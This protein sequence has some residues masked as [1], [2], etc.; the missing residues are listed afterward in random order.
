MTE[1]VKGH[2]WNHSPYRGVKSNKNCCACGW[3]CEQYLTEICRKDHAQ[4]LASLTPAQAA[5]VSD[6]EIREDI[7]LFDK[8]VTRGEQAV[9][10]CV[11]AQDATPRGDDGKLCRAGRDGDCIEKHA[12]PGSLAFP[13]P[14]AQ[15]APTV[16]PQTHEPPAITDTQ[17]LDWLQKEENDVFVGLEGFSTVS[18]TTF[19]IAG[20]DVGFHKLR[21]AIDDAMT[22]AALR[23]GEKADE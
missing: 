14:S 11:P 10:H 5:P 22:R 18:Y 19:Q 12:C 21:E 16:T 1:T 7:K 4:H 17:R 3:D 23:A 20:Y 8:L 6:A 15:P 2:E 13:Y 9:A